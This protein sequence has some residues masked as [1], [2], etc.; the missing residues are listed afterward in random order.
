MNLWINVKHSTLPR[1]PANIETVAKNEPWKFRY[2]S[3]I[4]AHKKRNTFSVVNAKKKNVHSNLLGDETID[5]NRADVLVSDPYATLPYIPVYDRHIVNLNLMM[6]NVNEYTIILTLN[7]Y[8]YEFYKQKMMVCWSWYGLR[9][10]QRVN[11]H[12]FCYFVITLFWIQCRMGTYNDE[13]WKQVW[14]DGI[15]FFFKCV[16]CIRVEDN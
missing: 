9:R 10:P 11:R 5:V 4:A 6:Q 15:F 12:C 7:I 1:I 3:Q 8:I 13:W 2:L 16:M 14:Y